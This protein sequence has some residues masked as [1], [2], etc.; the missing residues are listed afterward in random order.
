[1]SLSPDRKLDALGAVLVV[2]VIF[3]VGLAVFGAIE[4]SED[5]GEATPETNF[6]VERI[7]DSHVRLVHA[8]GDVVRGDELVLTID[9]RDRVPVQ[10]FPP[11]VSE[12]D[13]TI[14]RVSEGHT[15]RVYWT[16]G[17]GTQE[18]LDSLET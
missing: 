1:M 7:N 2:L 16:G 6:S 4:V 17:R 3:G 10:P 9:G 15:L 5:D 8:G 18:R 14:V 13:G 11:S 12:G